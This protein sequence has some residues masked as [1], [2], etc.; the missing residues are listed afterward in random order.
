MD[1]EHIKGD[2]TL[3]HDT[4]R[5]IAHLEMDAFVVSAEFS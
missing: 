1:S 4:H 2:T 3:N 5:Q